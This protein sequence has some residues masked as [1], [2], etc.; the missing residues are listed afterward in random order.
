MPYNAILSSEI[1]VKQPLRQELMQKIKDNFDAHEGRLAVAGDAS[2]VPNGSFEIDSDS[3]GIPDSWSRSLYAGGSAAYE[4]AAPAH[5]A[6]SYRFTH[7]GGAGNGG[8]YLESDYM[9]VAAGNNYTMSFL[10]W[11]SVSEMKNQ[12]VVRYFSAAKAYLSE[13]A[14]YSSTANSLVVMRHFASFMPPSNARF[15]KL[16]LI[17]GFTDTNVAG[18]ARFDDIRLGSVHP[19]SVP[20]W[21]IPETS[22]GAAGWTDRVSIALGSLPAG[23][24]ITL[25]VDSLLMVSGSGSFRLR[26]G[27]EYGTTVNFST[28]SWVKRT[29]TLTLASDHTADLLFLQVTSTVDIMWRKDNTLST[30]NISIVLPTPQIAL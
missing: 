3:D 10:L 29:L 24:V 11:A 23:A 1:Q 12:V 30:T 17:G 21:T 6:K 22:S 20:Q 8:G 7:P 2:G 18:S 9:E 16:R 19:G 26:M 15:I 28:Q 13:S 14:V 4:T 25:A 27:A 5:G